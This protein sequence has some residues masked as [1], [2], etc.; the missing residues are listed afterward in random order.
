MRFLIYLFTC[1]S[2]ILFAQPDST[3]IVVEEEPILIFVPMDS[4]L[5]PIGG[6]ESIQNRLIY[7]PNALER[8]IGGNVYVL[9]K[10]DSFGTPY[11]PFLIKGIGV[12]CD[13]E[14]IRLVMTA[15]YFPAYDKGKYTNY[16]IVIP[17]RFRLPNNE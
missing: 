8:R 17:V 12:G 5:K 3:E 16:E 2:I 15:K 6:L 9:V 1:N 14:A 10:I 4:L 7:P 11:D 13:E